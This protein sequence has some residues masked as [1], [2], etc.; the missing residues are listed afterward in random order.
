MAR[1]FKRKYRLIVGKPAINSVIIPRSIANPR[2]II[3]GTNGI[4]RGERLPFTGDMRYFTNIP[5]RFFEISGD[6]SNALQITATIAQSKE[7]GAVT[8]ISIY[9]LDDDTINDIKKDNLIILK[10]GYDIAQGD[11]VNIPG[12][13]G[14]EDLPDLL[15]AQVIQVS[16]EFPDLDKITTIIC[17]EA[18]TPKRNSKVSKSYATGITRLQ[19]LRDLLELVKG[20]GVPTGRITLP[21]EGTEERRI[22]DKPMFL[23][24]VAKGMLFHEIEKL[25]SSCNLNFFTALGRIYIDP[26]TETTL[27]TG[28]TRTEQETT[29]RSTTIFNITPNDVKA[30]MGRVDIATGRPSNDDDEAENHGLQLTLYLNG[31]ITVD[32]VARLRGFTGRDREYNGEYRIVSVVHKLDFRSDNTWDT[33]VVLETL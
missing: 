33:E 29:P 12:G 2:F 20:Q 26:T 4:G 3:G 27:G 11:P 25:C 19:V 24:Y 30:G 14:V 31:N 13:V 1:Q 8:E 15:V 17:G 18:M 9:N 28:V 21:K 23:G 32:L 22:L 7:P 5:P 10:A 6:S 16:T